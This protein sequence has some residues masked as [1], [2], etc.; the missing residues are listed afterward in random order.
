M[1]FSSPARRGKAPARTLVARAATLALL[2]LG[3]AAQAAPTV[4]LSDDTTL[5]YSLTLSYTGSMRTMA[6]SS[7]YLAAPDYDDGT[8]NFKRGD[9]VNNRTSVL[10]EIKLKHDNVGFLARATGFYDTVYRGINANNSP[11]TVNKIGPHNEFVSTTRKRSGQ[12]ARLLDFYGFGS[13]TVGND[14]YLSVKLG[15]HV[16]AWGESMF[17]ANISQGQ[18]PLDATKFNV[19]GTEAKEGYLPVPQISADLTL[20]DDLTA[21]GFYQ[22]HWEETRLNPV[23]DFFGS[24]SFGPGAQFMRFAPGAINS[25]PDHSG[26]IANFAGEIKPKNS[27]QWGLGLRWQAT[28]ATELGLFHYRYHDRVGSMFFDFTGDTQYSSFTKFGAQASPASAPYYKLAYFD[29]IKLTGVSLS[30]KIGDSVQFGGD[31]SY[32]DGAAVYLDNGAP[33]RG[34]YLQANVNALYMMGPSMLAHQ[35][36]LMG[37]VMH[38]RIVGVDALTVTSG[39]VSS[40]SSKYVYDGQTRGSTLLGVGAIFDYP[41]VFSGWDLSTSATWTQ[42]IQGSAIGGMGRDE[43]RLTLGAT[44]KYLGNLS[45]GLTWVNYLGS[46]DIAAGRTM[47]DRDYVSFNAKYTF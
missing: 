10:G 22:F 3:A 4:Y 6:P 9:L 27:G 47:A 42:N 46:A 32:R 11:S 33:A 30:T 2:T 1:D 45:L 12:D 13:W 15:Q 37:E 43:K 41:N 44:M 20:T 39:G 14:Q 23:G 34:R 21:T 40:T 35:T 18:V 28:D 7:V 25:L 19:P 31:L 24:D 29:N 36:T 8:R 16:V 26:A 17:W 5:D 38:Q